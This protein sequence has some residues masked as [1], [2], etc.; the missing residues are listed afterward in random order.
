MQCGILGWILEQK[1]DISRKIVKTQI[2]W[3]VQLI[4]WCRCSCPGF[5]RCT[6]MLTSGEELPVRSQL[7]SKSKIIQYC[8]FCLSLSGSTCFGGGQM[9]AMEKA[10]VFRECDCAILEGDPLAPVKPSNDCSP[11]KC[12]H[13]QC[14]KPDPLIQASPVPDSQKVR[15]IINVYCFEWLFKRQY[16]CC[17][18]WPPDGAWT[19]RMETDLLPT[20]QTGQSPP[21][22]FTNVPQS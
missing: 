16:C 8:S 19:P 22:Q 12:L 3:A 13:C 18:Q 15:V 7:S 9:H 4:I 2:R 21:S 1:K 5:D 20:F 10:T 14:S 17:A 6:I 11:G